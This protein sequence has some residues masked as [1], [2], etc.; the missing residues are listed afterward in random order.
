MI[1]PLSFPLIENCQRN[2]AKIESLNKKN[3]EKCPDL[4][5]KPLVIEKN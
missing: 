2:L 1:P 5:W 4:N 3:K